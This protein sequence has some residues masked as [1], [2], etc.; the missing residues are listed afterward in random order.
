MKLFSYLSQLVIFCTLVLVLS[1]CKDDDEEVQPIIN[2]TSATYS[3]ES[4][5]ACDI[6]SGDLAS[7]FIFE[8]EYEASPSLEFDGIEF[9]LRW[10]DGDQSNNIVVSTFQRSDDFVEFDWC[11][12]FGTTEWFELDATIVGE[13]ETVESNPVTI[14]VEKPQDAN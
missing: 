2:L 3:V 5:N 4:L 11:F 12:R 14:R 7:N 6:G 9:D 10:S 1:G 8:L 13:N